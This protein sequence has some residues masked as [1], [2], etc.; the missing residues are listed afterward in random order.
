MRAGSLIATGP[1]YMLELKMYGNENSWKLL[2]SS[3]LAVFHREN[4]GK[5][6]FPKVSRI[7]HLQC[8]FS[9]PKDISLGGGQRE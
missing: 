9:V 7:F 3:M 4:W 6:N 2:A 5:I 8:T 1:R